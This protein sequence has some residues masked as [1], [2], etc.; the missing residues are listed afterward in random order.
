[1]LSC[2]M[3]HPE[4]WFPFSSE[5]AF[6]R[7]ALFSSLFVHTTENTSL[8]D[9]LATVCAQEKQT[10]RGEEVFLAEL[11]NTCSMNE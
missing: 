6:T 1:M 10:C 2:V 8:F 4:L 9:K 7:N 11:H 5:N 3:S